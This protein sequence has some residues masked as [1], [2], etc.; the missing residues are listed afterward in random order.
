[1]T[2]IDLRHIPAHEPSLWLRN[3][4]QAIGR[5]WAAGGGTSCGHWTPRMS[6]ALWNHQFT[7]SNCLTDLL[8]HDP[9]DHTCDRCRGSA[10]T[11]NVAVVELGPLRVALGLCA[12]CADRE[13][14]S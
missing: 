5:E 7:C 4:I 11:L 1:V 8:V 10:D 2:S 3:E 9:E 6:T 13:V 14:R 12:D